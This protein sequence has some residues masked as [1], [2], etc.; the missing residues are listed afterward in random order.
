MKITDIEVFTVF[1]FRTNFTFVKVSTDEGITGVGEAT[2]EHK[3]LALAGVFKDLK[4]SLIGKA[5]LQIEYHWHNLYRDSVWRNGA[6]LMSGIS[7]IDQALW[8]IKGK[9]MG[10]PVYELLGGKFRDRIPAYANGWFSG[11]RTPEDFGAK[12]KDPVAMGFK[13]LKFDPF[14]KS[15]ME[16]S[17]KELTVS[18]DKVQAVR[19]SVGPE[20][21]IMVEGHGRFNVPTAVTIGREL[22]GLVNIRWFEEP[23]PPDSIEAL[24]TVKKQVRVPIATGERLYERRAFFHLLE[25]GA[26]DFLQPDVS[27]AGGISELRKIA[28]MAEAKY[29]SLS[30]HNPSGPVA[31][32]ATLQ[33]AAF[34]PN[35]TILEF[36]SVDVPYRD[37]FTT[38][39][40]VME[41]GAILIPNRPGLGI[42]L[43]VDNFSK[44]PYQATEYRHYNGNLTD[45]RPPDAGPYYKIINKDD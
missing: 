15:Y 41:D 28:A 26:A 5:P 19:D 18:M 16:I 44:Y 32:A 24:N 39:S 29:V 3:E 37:Q 42:D 14:G 9:M 31:C 35:F 22:E 30:P 8:D 6:V 40:L 13:A 36:M 1:S 45:I 11:A 34:L 12:A 27:H 10:V 33:L 43:K 25:L 20:I 23:I 38:E 17:H 4:H 7:G 21:D 2:L